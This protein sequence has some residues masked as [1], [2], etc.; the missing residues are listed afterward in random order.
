M[1]TINAKEFYMTELIINE[2]YLSNQIN[3]YAPLNLPF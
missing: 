2:D 1:S 3:E